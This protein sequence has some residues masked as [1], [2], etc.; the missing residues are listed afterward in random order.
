MN[1]DYPTKTEGRE[2]EDK[3]S[4]KKKD[5]S[6]QERGGDGGHQGEDESSIVI[7]TPIFIPYTRESRL[8]K[9]LQETD[10]L[11]GEATGSPRVKFIER[12][13]RG[14]VMD[15]LGRSNPWAKDW[16]CPRK[17]CLPCKSRM[18]MAA[19]EE[20][21]ETKNKASSKQDREEKAAIPK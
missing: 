2:G 9:N 15:V 8:R 13:G 14:T 1:K 16:Q 19:E 12:C 4:R 11:I 18:M 7:E 17:N 3:N 10:K 20:K 5:K 6:R 21:K